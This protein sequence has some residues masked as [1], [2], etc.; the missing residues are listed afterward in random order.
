MPKRTELLGIDSVTG[1]LNLG[2]F[3]RPATIA[4][5]RSRVISATTHQPGS[6][7]KQLDLDIGETRIPGSYIDCEDAGISSAAELERADEL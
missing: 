2:E 1:K 3:G 4:G 5:T 6:R 7:V